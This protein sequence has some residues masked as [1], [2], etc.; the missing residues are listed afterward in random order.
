MKTAFANDTVADFRNDI[1][2]IDVA[3]WTGIDSFA[4]IREHAAQQDAG[5]LITVGSDSLLLADV[6]LRDLDKRDFIF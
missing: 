5:V 4:D 1:D 3:Q 2:R 6:L